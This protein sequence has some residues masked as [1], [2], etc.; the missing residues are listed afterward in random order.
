MA[1][2]ARQ[3]ARRGRRLF[4]LGVGA[5]LGEQQV[6]LTVG[7]AEAADARCADVAGPARRGA[8]GRRRA[9]RLVEL[10]DELQHAAALQA[11]LRDDGQQAAVG[12]AR[13][14]RP[15]QQVQ[16]HGQRHG[17]GQL[18]R[19]LQQLQRPERRRTRAALNVGRRRGSR[20]GR[21]RCQRHL[22]T[23]QTHAARQG[24]DVHHHL[25]RTQRADSG[26]SARRVRPH[27]GDSGSG[28]DTLIEQHGAE[29]TKEDEETVI[30]PTEVRAPTDSK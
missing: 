18:R 11:A 1:R 21:H 29:P 7:Q 10:L 30:Q 8:L 13:R 27:S 9:G 15:R 17:D 24:R 22:H 25:P 12:A 14:R 16:R 2:T 28:S 5:P 6:Q 3:S 26:D 23:E 4:Q 20:S 19:R